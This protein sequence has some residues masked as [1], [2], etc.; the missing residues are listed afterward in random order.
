MKKFIVLLFSIAT[1]G[2]ASQKAKKETVKTYF[3]SGK[4]R[5]I[6]EVENGLKNGKEELYFEN[7]NL[8][9]VQ[10]FK[11]DMLVDSVYTYEKNSPSK[12]PFKGYATFRSRLEV[13]HANGQIF[14]VNDFK[15]NLVPDGIMQIYHGNGNLMSH[16]IYRDGNRDGIQVLYYF[17]GNIQKI[18]HYRA[19]QLMPPVIEFDSTGKMIN[20]VPA[21]D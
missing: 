5:S 7:G 6:T 3:P 2:C 11:D 17:N 20:Y 19:G 4:L 16:S 12:S 8:Y 1:I 15:E 21:T 9:M 10:F 18:A 14:S 13:R